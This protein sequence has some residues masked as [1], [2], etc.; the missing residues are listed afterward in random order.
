MK[1]AHINC[2]DSGSTGKIIADIVRESDSRGHDS[3]LCT[4]IKKQNSL[5]FKAY[6]TSS[7]WEQGICHRLNWL[8]VL[9]YGFAPVST[10]KILQILQREQPDVVHVH[11]ANNNM[12]NIYALLDY[13]KKNA[14]PTVVTNHAEFYYTGSCSHSH[15]CNQWI[16]GCKKCDILFEATCSKTFDVAP[17]AWR[18]M[19]YAFKGFHNIQIVSV[20]DWV[21]ERSSKSAILRD[22]PNMTIKNGVNTDIFK[23]TPIGNL[24]AKYDVPKAERYILHPTAFFSKD[25]LSIKG[26]RF[27]IELSEKLRK[28]DVMI[29]V[30]GHTDINQS[31]LPS[32]IKLLGLLMNQEELAAFYTLANLTVVASKKETF[33]MTVAESLCCGTPLVGFYAGG[34][35]SIAIKEYTRFVEYSN[36]EALKQAVMEMFK[37]KTPES[38]KQISDKSRAEYTAKKMAGSYNDLY[39]RMTNFKT[40]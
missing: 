29:L 5:P 31:D 4:S 11:C 30:A 9:Q 10:Y 40:E 18:K 8:G 26:G 39:G 24:M 19:N 16:E 14:I 35:E 15:G 32:N 37:F 12:V 20:S 22:L 21:C 36:V 23:P 2:T 33:G 38:S 1:I 13:L 28:E 7:R 3:L 17:K 6:Y 34:S 27:I 25:P